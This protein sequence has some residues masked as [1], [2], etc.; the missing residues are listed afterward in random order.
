RARP[1]SYRAKDRS[2]APRGRPARAAHAERS[3]AASSP[4]SL[5]D[6][7]RSCRP[8]LTCC[9]EALEALSCPTR[10]E[11]LGHALGRFLKR[12]TA[13]EAEP[14]CGVD[15]DGRTGRSVFAAENGA[16]DRRVHTRITTPKPF[17][18]DRLHAEITRMYLELVDR[19]VLNARDARHA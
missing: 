3:R 18:R 17:D 13:N 12:I 8:S 14:G 7:P 15:K 6:N 4:R 11:R 2:R 19:S 10:I 9:D 5:R 16:S 1:A